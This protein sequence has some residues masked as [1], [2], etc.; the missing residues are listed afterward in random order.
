MSRR[1]ALSAGDTVG[2]RFVIECE[3]GEGGM[4]R[5]Y[6]AVD[7][8]YDRPAALKVLGRGL[9]DDEEFRQRFEREAES[10]QRVTHPHVL[11]VWD[12]GEH[13]GLLYLAMP[14]CDTDLGTV[15]ATE[16]RLDAARATTIVAQVAWALDWAHRRGVVH[17]DVKPENILLVA[18]PG[19]GHA[20]LADFGLAKAAVFETLTLA[21]HPAGL[22]PAYAAPEQ[23]LGDHVGP[24][25]DQYAL[26]AT[27]YT[28]ISGRP[29]F[30]PR[31][32]PSL[33]EAHLAEPPPDIA[34]VVGDVP[35]GVAHALARGLSKDPDDRFTSCGELMSAVLGAIGPTPS[36][37]GL[38][39]PV[40][41]PA[42]EREPS[43]LGASD[44]QA[45][46]PPEED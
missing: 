11:P 17:R 29:P 25:A 18:G 23:W 15:L 16:G 10:A 27:L 33:R 13:E 26:A 9:A 30:H 46:W 19:E 7:T 6:E 4:S 2:G 36:R 32:G 21:G 3:L 39:S 42:I 43:T 12:H 28:C 38:A 14:L 31:R 41:A 44:A 8:R 1:V 34:L 20:Y 35:P 5:V 24:A 37:P 45:L 40:P 22:T